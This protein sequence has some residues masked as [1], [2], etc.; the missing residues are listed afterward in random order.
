MKKFSYKKMV[1]SLTFHRLNTIDGIGLYDL[2]VSSIATH[3]ALQHTSFLSVFDCNYPYAVAMVARAFLSSIASS[4]TPS[5]LDFYHG[6]K[7]YTWHIDRYYHII[8]R[9]Y[10][11]LQ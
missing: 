5:A 9:I 2:S 3:P 11:V 8:F 4:D 7:L 1:D 6:G 10:R